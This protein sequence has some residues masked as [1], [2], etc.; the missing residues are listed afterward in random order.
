MQSWFGAGLVGLFEQFLIICESF[1]AAVV[2]V[3][4]ID[5]LPMIGGEELEEDVGGACGLVITVEVDDAK[6]LDYA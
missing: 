4:I 5:M 1:V 6:I 3:A 2:G